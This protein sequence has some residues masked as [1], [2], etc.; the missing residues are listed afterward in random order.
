MA[1][2]ETAIGPIFPDAKGC[3][4]PSHAQCVV[5]EHIVKGFDFSSQIH[6]PATAAAAAV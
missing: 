2:A 6:E 3:L 5:V 4:N 1:P